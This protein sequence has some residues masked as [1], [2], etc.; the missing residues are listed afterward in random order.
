[1]YSFDTAFMNQNQHLPKRKDNLHAKSLK[2]NTNNINNLLTESRSINSPKALSPQQQQKLKITEKI[3]SLPS[4][5][6]Y[7]ELS[8]KL[9]RLSNKNHLK[10]DI[11]LQLK[12]EPDKLYTSSHLSPVNIREKKQKSIQNL[13]LPKSKSPRYAIIDNEY[14]RKS[15][16]K[17]FIIEKNNKLRNQFF[18]DNYSWMLSTNSSI[19]K[20]K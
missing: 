7:E 9:C 18:L 15:E 6:R 11:K 19:F 16:R 5:K 13:K 12:N 2:I 1:M 4:I 10:I 3:L 8:Q 20:T 17:Q 14:K